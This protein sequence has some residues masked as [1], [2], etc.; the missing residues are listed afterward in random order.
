MTR[1]VLKWKKY[2]IHS[3]KTIKFTQKK[4]INFIYNSSTN[5]ELTWRVGVSDKHP[6][7]LNKWFED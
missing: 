2:P 7:P 3:F 6:P 4:P 1:F 5:N